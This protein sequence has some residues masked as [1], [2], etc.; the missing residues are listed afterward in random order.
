[1]TD[2][3]KWMKDN[4]AR[5]R[6]TETKE[7]PGAAGQ[8][9][10]Y[11]VGSWTPTLVGSGTAGTFTYSAQTG[12][13]TRIGNTCFIRARVRIT[14][15]TV[16]PVGNLQINGLPFAGVAIGVSANAGGGAFQLWQSITLPA[17][18][19]QLMWYIVGG[20]SFINISRGGSNV[21]NANVQGGELV[22]VGGVGNFE[23]EGQYR[24]S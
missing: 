15:I 24:V 6:Q 5:L 7:V 21:V 12:D 14:A 9:T 16:A 20:N 22:I 11:A 3:L 19:T 13:Y 2:M 10:F 18:Y 23:I 4:E 1:M 17:G 8:S